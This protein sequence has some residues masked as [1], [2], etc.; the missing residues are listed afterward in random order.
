[1]K[2]TG[3]KLS[4]LETHAPARE[5]DLVRLPGL[6]RDRWLHG[7]TAT[8]PRGT[9]AGQGSGAGDRKRHDMVM[10]VYTDEGIEGMCTA[11]A[12]GYG[13]VHPD[14]VPQLARLVAGEDPLDRE[15]LYQKLHTG[16]RWV[17]RSQGWFGAF[18]NCLWD[19]AGKAAGMPVYALLGRVRERVPCYL[20]IRGRTKE[21]AADDARRAMSEGFIATKDHFYHAVPENIAW[22]T[23]VREAVG[24]DID[25]MHDPVAIYDYQDALKVGR[26][27]EELEYRWLEEPL[28][29]RQHNLM[30][31]LCDALDIPVLA[32]ETLMNDVDLQ[33]Q[34]VIS[35]ATDMIRGNARH[36]STAVLKLAHFAELYGTTVELNGAG[37]LY[38]LVHA[39]LLSAISNTTYYEFFPGGHN[40]EAAREIGVM[41]PVVPED[42]H[43]AAPSAPGWG[44]E[45]DMDRFRRIVVA[46]YGA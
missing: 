26:A 43:I 8:P 14:D 45:W 34:Y 24:P 35:G 21:E 39:H 10:H 1:M 42:G 19:I 11:V 29:E 5:F 4:V 3:V 31:K 36:G 9:P 28:P 38:G 7:G 23:A 40:D 12:D 33:A 25:L 2:I 6:I 37:G 18:D 16:T 17:Y 15:K 13:R 32:P 46:E 41:N 44:A 30:Q 22:L 27:L 20:N